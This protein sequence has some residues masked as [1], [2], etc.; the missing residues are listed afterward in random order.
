MSWQ[1]YVDGLVGE[2]PNRVASAR[3]G[4]TE[5]TIS[6]W[7]SGGIKSPDA[8]QV[9]AFARGYDRPVLEA[10]IAAG[11]L[12][13]EEARQRPSAPPT[14]TTLTDDEL[15]D[16]VRA[17]MSEGR[18]GDAQHAAPIDDDP[19]GA[20]VLPLAA[21]R[22]TSKGRQRKRQADARGEEPQAGPEDD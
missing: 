10:F 1:D 15:L 22:G 16:E 4:V 18:D 17:R 7:R 21:K 20:P 11:F 8:R 14:L 3:S 6:R 12:E 2:M 13:P 5:A 9:A 19:P